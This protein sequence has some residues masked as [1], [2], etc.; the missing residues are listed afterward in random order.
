M[1]TPPRARSATGARPQAARAAG[2]QQEKGIY[3]YGI[4]PAGVELAAEVPGVGDPPARVRVA[5]CGDLAALISE[6]DLAGRLGSP[7]DLRA[8]GAILDATAAELPVLPLR[9][10]AVV[11]NEDAVTEVLL[12]AHHDEF[13]AALTQLEG[14]AEFVVK[15]RYA[16]QTVLGEVLAENKRAARLADQIRGR[17]PDATRHARIELGQIINVAI[18]AKRE[19]DTR[20]LGQA[21]DGRCVASV[22]REPTHE[23]DAVHAAILVE[24]SQ[25]SGLRQVVQDLARAQEGR[26]ELRLLGPMAAYDFAATTPAAGA[27]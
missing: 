7:E 22:V 16:Q 19:Q 12:A 17:N 8:H 2:A 20:A 5:R 15:G 14:R 10:G 1:A 18:T 4:V 26:I 25:Q 3:V 23:L 24:A 27:R 11:A 6:V 21:L 9:F 13:A